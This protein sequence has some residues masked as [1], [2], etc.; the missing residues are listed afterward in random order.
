MGLETSYEVP[1]PSGGDREG[2]HADRAIQI[3]F[4]PYEM[5]A[6]LRN[7]RQKAESAI[8]ETGANILY[9]AFGFLEWFESN[10]SDG[11]RIAP[12][13]LVPAR[14]KKGQLNRETRTYEYTLGYSG[15]DIVPN[16]SLREKLRVDFALALP[17]LD[18]NTRPEAY[19]EAVLDAIRDNQPRWRLRR[20]ITLTLLNFSKLL[21]Y[22]DLAPN[23]WPE[24]RRITDHPVVARFL[25]GDG[26]D[27][28]E[29][30]D[31]PGP[32]FG[33]EYPIDELEHVHDKYPLIDDADSSQ[34]S[35]L[36]DAVDGKNLVIEGPPGTGKSQTITNL[37]AAAMSQGKKI[38]FVA[39]KLA[40]LEVVKRRLDAAR[41]G[42]F[43]LELHS[44]KSQKRKA[45]DEV[46][47]RL[48]K[49]GHYRKPGEIHADI[50]RFEELKR[51]LKGHVERINQPWKHTGRTLHEI[52]MAATRYREALGVNPEELHP[53]GYS[54]DNFDATSQRRAR[55]QVV[56]FGDAHK[57]VE[58]QLDDGGSLKQHPWYGV[59]NADL[60]IFDIG[61]VIATLE[62]WQDALAGLR[63]LEPELAQVLGCDPSDVPETLADLEQLTLDLERLPKLQGDE[64]LDT[65]PALT[66]NVLDKVKRY[67]R[68]FDDIQTFYRTLSKEVGAEVLDDLSSVDRFLTGSEQLHGL[69]G[70]SVVLG[71]IAQAIQ[72]LERL[73]DELA[74]IQDPVS[75]I[76][77]AVGKAA[78]RHLSLTESGLR[79]L[80]RFVDLVSSLP[81]AHW[82]LRDELFDNDELDEALP[83]IRL[84]LE[85]LHR[86]RGDLAGVFNIGGLPHQETLEDLHGII[87]G[88]GVFRW[89]K[90]SWRNARRQLLTHAASPRVK[91]SALMP[92]LDKATAFSGQRRRFEA[93]TAYRTLLGDHAK[94]LDTDLAS[95]ESVRGWYRR[96]RQAYGVGFGQKVALG[97]AVIALPSDLGKAIRSLSE[98]GVA[99]Q[100][101]KM[102]AD[103][104]D[105]KEI[106]SPVTELQGGTAL[107]VGE[108]GLIGRLLG[109]LDEALRACGPLVSDNEISLSE[110]SKRIK[111]L[112]SLR[113]AVA[114]WN[115]ADLD[116]QV[117]NGRLGLQVGLNQN[118]EAGITAA[119]HTLRV[120]TCLDREMSTPLI[121]RRVYAK[122]D[123]ST[124]DGLQGAA[125]RLRT[126]IDRHW[127]AYTGFEQLVALDRDAWTSTCGDR[128]PSLIERNAKASGQGPTLQNWLDYVRV[129]DQLAAI[130]LGR[131]AEAV[132][133]WQM[134]VEQAEEAFHA[135]VY[136]LLAREILREEPELG[137]FSGRSQESL[138]RQFKQY[139]D[140]LKRLQCER[141]A[142][143]VDQAPAPRGNSRG[144]VSEY[145]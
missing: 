113:K 128:I 59:R 25:V 111:A 112:D 80:K 97:T 121:S 99:G 144:R 120:A 69:V 110:L 17:D 46:G 44:H 41:L 51:V 27:Q 94:G 12:L 103:L 53:D 115:K 28:P 50:A 14:L 61:R 58:A 71:V 37:I 1:T 134:P 96:V 49:S 92:L 105:L 65:L 139:D 4:F 130:R 22:L 73:Q 66:G 5:E 142:W 102:L 35:A 33:E 132:E 76:Q 23:R 117:F 143:Q 91:F 7:L 82:K 123:R 21:M 140:R 77:A 18:E 89:L 127:E 114:M 2:K 85:A 133:T 79:E 137:R 29:G 30:P 138:Q 60:Q 109:S 119:R 87:A 135:G 15:E 86:L 40:A 19:F 32:G 64:L 104:T 39:E 13:F 129:R 10:D 57:A 34:H 9:L 145:T 36:V 116:E 67:L 106:F 52:F 131:M 31:D 101:D 26:S 125:T 54:G 78:G 42:D 70:N 124:F 63:S 81:P 88:G 24:E 95:T 100:L 6:L 8:E 62:E 11:A 108:G 126:A 56:A 48:K 75:A 98:R 74:Q 118:N 68:L 84:E 83:R 93:N 55:D 72:R 47:E 90:G 16:L 45:L 136:D 20:Y 3:L 38:L 122:P 43:C 107:M 141:I